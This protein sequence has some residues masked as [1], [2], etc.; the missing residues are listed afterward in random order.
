MGGGSAKDVRKPEG[1]PE[2]RR[3]RKERQGRSG[4]EGETWTGARDVDRGA[5]RLRRASGAGTWRE[6]RG[7][8]VRERRGGAR[9]REGGE[10][11][12]EAA[13][14][15]NRRT[16]GSRRGP[17]A[18]SGLQS[19]GPGDRGK[20]PGRRGSAFFV[21]SSSGSFRPIDTCAGPAPA[22][23]IFLMSSR[24]LER[25]RAALQGGFSPGRCF[26]RRRRA[27]PPGGGDKSLPPRGEAEDSLLKFKRKTGFHSV[28]K[29]CI[30]RRTMGSFLRLL[31]PAGREP[32]RRVPA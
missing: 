23:N 1:R 18:A 24:G 32:L 3:K 28:P 20:R 2:R 5:R 16:R 8:R 25:A 19:R 4:R 14:P 11:P 31:G 22:A 26:G 10:E 29:K 30:S 17:T 15:A 6:E 13:G 9:G 12:P 7:T 27:G 21:F